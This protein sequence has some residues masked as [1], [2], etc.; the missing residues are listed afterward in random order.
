VIELDALLGDLTWAIV[1]LAA[2]AGIGWRLFFF[3]RPAR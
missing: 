2:A 3:A 1:A